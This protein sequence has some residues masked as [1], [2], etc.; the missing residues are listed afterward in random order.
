MV[1]EIRVGICDCNS[2]YHRALTG[3]KIYF[4]GVGK[5]CENIFKITE[6]LIPFSC[7]REALK[8]F[9]CHFFL[10]YHQAA[11]RAQVDVKR[12][13]LI[14][15]SVWHYW[16]LYIGGAYTGKSIRNFRLGVRC[17]S[18]QIPPSVD[19]LMEG[20]NKLLANMNQSKRSR[21]LD[22][23]TPAGWYSILR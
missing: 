14:Y 23:M 3:R 13:D 10:D 18:G 16:G 2:H 1:E 7:E 5:Q 20:I 15:N 8:A 17:W 9:R 19:E 21:W 22:L 11:G 12:V 6:C 4:P